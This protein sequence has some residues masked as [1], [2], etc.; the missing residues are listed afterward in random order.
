MS[1]NRPNNANKIWIFLPVVRKND[2]NSLDGDGFGQVSRT[3]DVEP[4]L[5]G[6]VVR[7]KLE[8]DDVQNPLQAVDGARNLNARTT[9]VGLHRFLVTLLAKQNGPASSGGDLRE[10]VHTFLVQRVAHDD[11]EDGQGFVHHGQRPVLQLAGQDA[12]GMH[13]GQLFDFQSPLQ[14]S[15]VV[16]AASHD[17]QAVLFQEIFGQLLDLRPQFQDF[18]DEVRQL[19]ETFDDL[20]APS[21]LGDAVVGQHEGQEHEGDELRGVRLG[22]SDANFRPG[23]QMDAAVRLAGDGATDG[24]GHADAERAARLAIAHGL[25]RVGGFAGLGHED[26]DVVAE[27]GRVTIEEIRGQLHHDGQ[28]GQFFQDGPGGDGGMVGGPA[29]DQQK[30]FGATNFRDVVLDATQTHDLL[31]EGGR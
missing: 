24:V 28:L 16:E 14:A 4:L 11:H 30:P 2:M 3:V 27:D 18:L 10:R 9:G 17:Q 22:G 7:K 12:L 23:V 6:D 15:G 8:R 19:V 13:V 20:L 25:H 1:I 26:A 5:Q 29:G 21:A 31:G